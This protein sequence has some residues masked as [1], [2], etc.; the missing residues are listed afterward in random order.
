MKPSCPPSM[1]ARGPRHKKV[2]QKELQSPEEVVHSLAQVQ[3][4]VTP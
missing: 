1:T 4:I 3:G 2:V